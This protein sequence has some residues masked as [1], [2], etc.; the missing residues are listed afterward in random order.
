MSDQVRT[1]LAAVVDGKTLSLDDAR[2]AMGSVM[3]GEATP[4]LLAALLAT[5]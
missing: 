4:A 3:D 5:C 1:A 2:D